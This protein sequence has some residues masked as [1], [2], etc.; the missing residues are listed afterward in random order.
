VV[1]FNR[2]ATQAPVAHSSLFAK[3]EDGSATPWLKSPFSSFP[4]GKTR[5]ARGGVGVFITKGAGS[6]P[7]SQRPGARSYLITP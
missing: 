3:G 2:Q 5:A 6:H 1:L 7:P 4:Q